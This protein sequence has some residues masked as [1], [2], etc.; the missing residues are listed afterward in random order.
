MNA[1]SIETIVLRAALWLQIL[2]SLLKLDGSDHGGRICG[3][4]SD[5]D[6]GKLLL[7]GY[8]VNIWVEWEGEIVRDREI[9]MNSENFD[10]I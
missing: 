6:K 1:R 2:P 4:E 5:A 8:T 3:E 9:S 10:G 7:R